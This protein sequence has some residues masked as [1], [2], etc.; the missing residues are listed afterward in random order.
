MKIMNKKLI[1]LTL[2][3]AVGFATVSAQELVIKKKDG[4]AQTVGGKLYFK[5][6]GDTDKW[7]VTTDANGEYSSANDISKLRNASVLDGID[8]DLV[9]YQSPSYIDYYISAG[10]SWADRAKWNLANV[11][12]PSVMLAE[13]GYYYMYCTDAGYGDPHKE[14]VQ[15]NK[16]GH[17]QCRRSKD[18]VNWEYMGATMY[19]LPSWVQPKLN[20]IRKAMG[21]NNS[22]ANFSDDLQCGYWAPCA[23]KVK[24][25]LDRMYY[26]IVCPG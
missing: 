14:D 15:G 18:L 25:G 4:S 17:F 7:S 24:D 23:R 12:D 5:Q 21:L 10:S 2:L 8:L 20:E 1:S 22:T 9:K 3:C 6:K 11:H 13:D 26:C 19:G 16:H